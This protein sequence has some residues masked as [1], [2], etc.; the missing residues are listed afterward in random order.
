[1][2][3]EGERVP[4]DVTERRHEII[5]LIVSAINSTQKGK[6]H[7]GIEGKATAGSASEKK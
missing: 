3:L 4:V 1:M 2:W 7:R 5:T 6:G